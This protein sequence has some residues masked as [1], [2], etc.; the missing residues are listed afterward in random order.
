MERLYS[1]LN[2]NKP[3]ETGNLTIHNVKKKWLA[4]L[5]L[6]AVDGLPVLRSIEGTVT[7][8]AVIGQLCMMKVRVV[9]VPFEMDGH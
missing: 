9:G 4:W 1:K 5:V 6:I 3:T 8:T 2:Q 7:G